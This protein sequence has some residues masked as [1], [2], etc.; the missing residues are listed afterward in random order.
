[1]SIFTFC[2]SSLYLHYKTDWQF[3]IGLKSFGYF[4]LGI[5]AAG[6]I[7][8][9]FAY[10]S[11]KLI[12]FL[13][14]KIFNVTDD[15]DFRKTNKIALLLGIPFFLLGIYIDFQATRLFFYWWY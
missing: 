6:I 4:V 8:G 11:A 1:M 5:L 14:M 7:L 3:L 9:M 13:L 10:Y 2:V 12:S 15:Y